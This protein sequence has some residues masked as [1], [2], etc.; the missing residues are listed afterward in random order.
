M[1]GCSRSGGP[2]V[3]DASQPPPS[4]SPPRSAG[5]ADVPTSAD[6]E[7]LLKSAPAQNGDAGG[8]NHGK[9]MWGAI[10]DRDGRLCALSASTDDKPATWPGSRAIAIAKASTS[11]AFSSDVAP[12]STARLYTLNQPGHSLW[13]AANGNPLNP[14][15]LGA[16]DDVTTGIGQV[17]GGTIAFGGGLALFKGQIASRRSRRQRRHR[18]CRPR[19]RQA[20][21]AGG[22]PRAQLAYPSDEIVYTA[23]DG[24]SP[25]CSSAVP[26]H[27][28]RR[29]Q[30]R[31][32]IS[33]RRLLRR[34]A[35][36]PVVRLASRNIGR[37][38]TFVRAE[39]RP[40]VGSPESARK[41][42]CTRPTAMDTRV[43]RLLALALAGTSGVALLAC[44]GHTLDTSRPDSAR[45][46]G[47]PVASN[48]ATLQE[49]EG[50]WSCR[51]KTT[52]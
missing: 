21:A 15:C 46:V 30:N 48:P 9:A 7:K 27:V 2:Q 31:R 28:S 10:V 26:E 20:R 18:L 40:D 49:D 6:L 34:P 47:G 13:G 3:R 37:R 4:S 8:L 11:N 45:A 39:T 51:R 33:C 16:A 14:L 50:Q 43:A 23:A 52:R 42:S 38:M 5:C 12:M 36:E 35:S 19:D 24:P 17:C 29:Q 32:R 41:P 1:S 22:R 44:Q 25:L